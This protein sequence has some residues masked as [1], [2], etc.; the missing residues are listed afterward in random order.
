[1]KLQWNRGTP[2]GGGSFPA[3]YDN[4]GPP[5][6]RALTC[7]VYLNPVR[8][9]SRAPGGSHR[10]TSVLDPFPLRLLPLPLP[11]GTV[12]LA[13]SLAHRGARLRATPQEWKEGDGGEIVLRPFLEQPIRVPPKMNRAVRAPL[14]Q[15]PPPA[16]RACFPRRLCSLRWQLS[17]PRSSQNHRR[18]L[19]SQQAACLCDAPLPPRCSSRRTGCST[20][21]SRPWRSASA[22]PRGWCAY[23]RA[24]VA[25]SREMHVPRRN[26]LS[27]ETSSIH[28]TAASQLLRPGRN[29][30]TT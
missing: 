26:T 9:I 27:A 20:A 7:I 21:S 28:E 13:G 17:N 24:E 25:F 8:E 23:A 4:P 5:S 6:K 16:Q 15:T 30:A 19:L 12:A 18:P 3:H 1:M 2:A 10:Q 11:R 22:S 14:P 29:R